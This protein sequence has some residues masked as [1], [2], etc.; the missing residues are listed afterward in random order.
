MLK[1]INT[2]NHLLHRVLVIDMNF[3]MYLKGYVMDGEV[4]RDFLACENTY[5]VKRLLCKLKGKSYD[6]ENE[7]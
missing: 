7:T 6:G 1:M 5:G 3:L 2:L 4:A